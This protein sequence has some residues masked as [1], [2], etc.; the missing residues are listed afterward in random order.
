M[1]ARSLRVLVALVL[2]LAGVMPV[3]VHAAPT[4]IVM[5]TAAVGGSCSEGAGIPATGAKCVPLTCSS[6]A[7]AGSSVVLAGPV[8]IAQYRSR[9]T[10]DALVEAPRWA[11]LASSPD[12]FPPRDITPA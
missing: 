6:A 5:I 4:P 12:P 9:S 8:M 2:A 11:G 3:S 1:A 7:C 10:T